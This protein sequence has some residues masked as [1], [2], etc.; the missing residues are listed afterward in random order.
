M[1]GNAK[2][3]K[4]VGVSI[5]THMYMFVYVFAHLFMYVRIA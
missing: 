4:L 1:V 2:Y 3:T 5:Q